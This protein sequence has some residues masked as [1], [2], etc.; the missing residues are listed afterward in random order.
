MNADSGVEELITFLDGIFIKDSLSNR[1][2]IRK[3]VVSYQRE[4][5]MDV[6]SYI[7]KYEALFRRAE[8]NKITYPDD[9]KGFMIMEE[10]NLSDVHATGSVCDQ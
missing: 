3:K 6:E 1:Y 4:K 10:A 2:E 5:G 8:K 9:F 7:S